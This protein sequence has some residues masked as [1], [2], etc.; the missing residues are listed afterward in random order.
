MLECMQ[1]RRPE[2][3]EDEVGPAIEEV[4]RRSVRNHLREIEAAE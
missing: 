2:E 1:V 4:V 3:D